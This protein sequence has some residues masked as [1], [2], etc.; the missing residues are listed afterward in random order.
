MQKQWITD[1]LWDALDDAPEEG[2]FRPLLALLP[3]SVPAKVLMYSQLYDQINAKLSGLYLTLRNRGPAAIGRGDELLLLQQRLTEAA[4]PIRY[5]R[6]NDGPTPRPL[7]L[8]DLVSLIENQLSLLFECLRVLPSIAPLTGEGPD[9]ALVL[10]IY[11]VNGSPGGVIHERDTPAFALLLSPT[12]G[13]AKLQVPHCYVRQKEA[14]V[15]SKKFGASLAAGQKNTADE[16]DR[17]QRI[18]SSTF[19]FIGSAW[20]DPSAYLDCK[21]E[22]TFFLPRTNKD[23]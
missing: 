18:T 6:P 22:T 3:D 14:A 11:Q 2:K 9:A 17:A 1:A 10:A 12:P 21:A 8:V 15:P 13:S 16:T 7:L 4:H 23:K 20:L 5:N 19:Y